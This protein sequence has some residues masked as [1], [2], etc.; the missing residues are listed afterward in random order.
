MQKI[1]SEWNW[2]DLERYTFESIMKEYKN[3]IFFIKN[4]VAAMDIF[5]T[6]LCRGLKNPEDIHMIP[7]AFK[8]CFEVFI[9]LLEDPDDNY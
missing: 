8:A 9:K 4:S 6:Y 5:C 2:R 7:K 1:K 3:K